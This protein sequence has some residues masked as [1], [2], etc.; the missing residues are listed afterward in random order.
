MRQVLSE[1][2]LGQIQGASQRD[3]WI[4]LST[5]SVDFQVKGA[6]LVLLLAWS[7]SLIGKFGR[8]Q[9]DI[10]VAFFVPLGRELPSAGS[11][12]AHEENSFRLM[13]PTRGF[14]ISHLAVDLKPQPPN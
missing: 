9:V 4:I 2:G 11:S 10:S 14:S 3:T 6:A 13:L 8:T 5:P 7:N 12:S 1:G